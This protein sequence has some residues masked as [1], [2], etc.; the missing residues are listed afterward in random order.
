MPDPQLG[1]QLLAM[2]IGCAV[3]AGVMMVLISS[4]G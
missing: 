3:I 1:K 2:L 4:G